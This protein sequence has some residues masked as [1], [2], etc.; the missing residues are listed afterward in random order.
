MNTTFASRV[1][2]LK[3]DLY[4]PSA[5][6]DWF[7]A[8][9]LSCESRPWKFNW[10]A[11]DT[12]WRLLG[13]GGEGVGARGLF[14]WLASRVTSVRFHAGLQSPW[15]LDHGVQHRG[16]LLLPRTVNHCASLHL[17]TITSLYSDIVALNQLRFCGV[18]PWECVA[19]VGQCQRM[20]LQT[21]TSDLMSV[22]CK[23]TFYPRWPVHSLFNIQFLNKSKSQS[24]VIHAGSF[25]DSKCV[26]SCY[27]VTTGQY[28]KLKWK[29]K[30]MSCCTCKK[31]TC[32]CAPA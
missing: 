31:D 4:L 19:R 14:S 21:N 7:T 29:K 12:Y 11:W 24:E 6:K 9:T 15:V 30:N 10:K 28:Y 3:E 26:T 18:F 17:P 2:V 16:Q 25:I 1:H 5:L 13:R 8:K 20:V 32:K 22:A 27:S 23:L